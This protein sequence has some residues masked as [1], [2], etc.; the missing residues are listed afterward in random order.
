MIQTRKDEYNMSQ[1]TCYEFKGVLT[2]EKLSVFNLKSLKHQLINNKQLEGINL[3][4][5]VN[6]FNIHQYS[7]DL[8]IISM[9]AV[10]YITRRHT[11]FGIKEVKGRI[12]EMIMSACDFLYEDE[13][14][15]T[16]GELKD[17]LVQKGFLLK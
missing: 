11:G 13:E 16:Y 12:I 8:L 7:L 14:E 6:I 9:D 3:S 17:H 2:D 15:K 10:K 4:S 5:D 1:A